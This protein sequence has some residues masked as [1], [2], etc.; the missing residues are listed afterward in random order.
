[1]NQIT[2][3]FSVY[4]QNLF[5]CLPSKSNQIFASGNKDKF[6]KM[7]CLNNWD[8]GTELICFTINEKYFFSL[9][10]EF[11]HA[12]R[13][14]VYVWSVWRQILIAH[15]YICSEIV[16]T[17]CVLLHYEIIIFIKNIFFHLLEEWHNLK[18]FNFLSISLK[19]I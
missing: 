17:M 1:M 11:I 4:C 13:G 3:F 14:Q 7:Y 16:V 10:Q 6:V 19:I 15:L 5:K 12:G 18:L 8:A 2:I 9:Q